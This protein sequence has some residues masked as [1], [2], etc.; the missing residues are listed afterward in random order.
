MIIAGSYSLVGVLNRVRELNNRRPAWYAL[1][2][3]Q[4]HG[5]LEFPAF[6]NG[7]WETM[8]KVGLLDDGKNHNSE[9]ILMNHDYFI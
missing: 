9:S 6:D 5:R 7:D 8:A 2:Q 4:D 3:A 1:R